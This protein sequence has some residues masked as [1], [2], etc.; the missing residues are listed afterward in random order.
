MRGSQ[1]ALAILAWGVMLALAIGNGVLRDKGYGPHLGTGV[2]R[3]LSSVLLC[4]AIAA[5][6]YGYLWL[7]PVPREPSVL[8]AIGAF[9]LALSLLFEF[10]FFHFIAGKPWAELLA[11]YNVFKGRLLIF[12]WLT[13]LFAPVLIGQWLGP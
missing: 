3:A 7:V 8:W 6:A 11:E 12:V 13:T 2:A 4:A 10:G 1:I 5:V 9:W